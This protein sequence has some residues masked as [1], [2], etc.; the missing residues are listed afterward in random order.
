[1]LL[2]K[3]QPFAIALAL[4]LLIGI[5][6][7]RSHP[8]NIQAIGLRTFVLFALLGA[9]AAAIDEPL[10]AWGITFF[11][12]MVIALSYLRTTRGMDKKLG[13]G[14]TTEVA[15]IVTFG[16]GFLAHRDALITLIIGVV[17]LIV[18]LAKKRLHAFSR[19]KLRAEELQATATLLVLATGFVPFLPHRTIDP[20]QLFN[21]Q[22]FAVL[23]LVI[24]IMQF[25]AYAITRIFGPQKGVFFSG[26]LSGFVSSAVATATF[27]QQVKNKKLTYL[28][29]VVA[30]LCATI[31]MFIKLIALV[32]AVTPALV[33]SLLAP[34]LI[35]ICVGGSIAIWLAK[36]VKPHKRAPELPNPLALNSVLR[37]ASLLFFMLIVVSLA[38]RSFGSVGI[39]IVVFLGGLFDIHSV[40]YAVLNLYGES[41]LSSSAA[42]TSIGL[43]VVASF[44][45]KIL[46]L[47]I[48][49]NRRFIF[50]GSFALI[51][52]AS[53]TVV[54]WYVI[55]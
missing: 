48:S 10:V 16:L 40:S 8:P 43:A 36:S 12:A 23:V 54:T 46:M 38:Q 11:V 19:E 30:I 53:A 9:I 21:P 7:E 17:V 34:A 18:L 29:A 44:V 22:R 55:R 5:E 31:A 42:V 35:G 39:N 24:G 47:T 14:I 1:M 33:N 28:A 20:W 27:T 50:I 51:S 26:L 37:L 52:M 49:R 41:Q 45:S 3:I 15:A 2:E 6:R 32:A 25:G 4:G 13:L